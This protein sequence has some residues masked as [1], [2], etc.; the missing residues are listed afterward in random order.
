MVSLE[1]LFVRVISLNCRLYV[2]QERYYYRV[3]VFRWSGSRLA[4]HYFCSFDVEDVKSRICGIIR[5][6]ELE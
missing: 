3:F 1:E 6:L 2:E 4:H 5:L